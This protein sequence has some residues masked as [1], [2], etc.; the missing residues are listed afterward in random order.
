R[1]YQGKIPVI[2]QHLMSWG[3]LREDG[4]E[5]LRN[6]L[7]F[8]IFTTEGH[9]GEIYA[10]R[11][12]GH[13]TSPKHLY[14]KGPH[15]GVF[16]HQVFRG[17]MPLILCESIIDA[18]SFWVHDFRHVSATFGCGGFTEEML[19]SIQAKGVDT[20]W[21]AFD[22]DQAGNEGANKVAGKLLSAGIAVERILLPQGE[23]VNSF[24]GQAANP[25]QALSDLL[26]RRQAYESPI[27]PSQKPAPQQTTKH[28]AL[29]WENNQ[30]TISYEDR[31]Y[32]LLGVDQCSSIMTLKVHLRITQG[33]AIFT[34]KIDL[35]SR[36][37]RERL[38]VSAS[39]E[40]RVKKDI[41]KADI[42]KLLL[43][44]E[45][46]VEKLLTEAEG[47]LKP[48]VPEMTPEEAEEALKFLQQ[49]D[50][51]EQILKDFETVGMVGEETNKL[52]GYLVA[53][54]RKL[55]SPLAVMIQSASAA[56]KTTLMESI[57]A[58]MPPEDQESW[59]AVTEQALYYLGENQMVHKIITIAEEEG[60][61]KATYPLKILQ[62]EKQLK[63]ATT[64]KDP[65]SGEF[66]VQEKLVKGPCSIFI[67]S[68]S[69]EIDEELMNRFLRLTGNETR[70]QTKAIQDR[71]REKRSIAGWLKATQAEAFKIKHHN[72]QRL[73]N[74]LKV[75]NPYHN[76]L[77]FNHDY[78]RARRDNEKYL[79]L[80][81]TITFLHQYQRRKKVVE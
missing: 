67:T 56:G 63:I 74:P 77:S 6:C 28:S 17:G 64:I 14:L 43:A 26:T 15:R 78:L 80:I 65:K 53:T 50:L 34:D 41:L 73:L 7:T 1:T 68:T 79:G 44:T 69:A 75:H 16:N 66:K 5:H 54:S 71:Q 24:M 10:R 45:T 20:V 2:R 27:Q 11:V 39:E 70:E 21:L 72:A 61:E 62:S 55:E 81:E 12:G 58:F 36:F 76:Q 48:E 9:L 35:A 52:V 25:K 29:K 13:S 30:A 57:L 37:Q 60:A 38:I 3:I 8:P 51:I 18:L 47:N 33:E 40:L 46:L 23:D 4:V 59:S 22:N 42:G 32:R 19:Q 49:P 31:D